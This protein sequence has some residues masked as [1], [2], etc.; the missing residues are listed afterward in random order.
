MEVKLVFWPYLIN[1]EK[2]GINEEF[3]RKQ[4]YIVFHVHAQFG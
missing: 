1:P 3:K 2:Q 4:R